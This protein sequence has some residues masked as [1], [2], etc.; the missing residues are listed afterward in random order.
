MAQV[1]QYVV[2]ALIWLIDAVDA[3]L[4]R[5]GVKLCSL[6]RSHV[7]G[8]LTPE[9]LAET[10]QPDVATPFHVFLKVRSASPAIFSSAMG[11][12]PKNI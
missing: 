9:Q 8:A 6:T 11:Q 7:L 2:L 12:V 10:T 1:K 3:L 5:V 4:R